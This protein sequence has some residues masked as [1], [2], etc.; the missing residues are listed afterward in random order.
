VQQLGATLGVQLL[1]SVYLHAAGPAA[2]ARSAFLV[3]AALLAAAGITGALMMR[4]A[5]TR[6]PATAQAPE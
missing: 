1:G 2:G 3:A 4:A 6:Q 5:P